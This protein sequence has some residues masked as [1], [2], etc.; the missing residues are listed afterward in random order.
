MLYR[1][2]AVHGGAKAT[3]HVLV[4][5]DGVKQTTLG[6]FGTREEAMQK[7]EGSATMAKS[8]R[9]N[10]EGQQLGLTGSNVAAGEALGSSYKKNDNSGLAA[11]RAAETKGGKEAS[12]GMGATTTDKGSK[13]WEGSSSSASGSSSSTSTA[14]SASGFDKGSVSASASGGGENG[15]LNRI[16][17]AM[18]RAEG[19]TSGEMPNFSMAEKCPKCGQGDCKCGNMG[20]SELCKRCSKAENMC[21]CTGM[22]K[23]RGPG[24]ARRR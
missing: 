14:T 17:A 2:W 19:Q 5:H 16:K 9:L 22:T 7:A 21:K 4:K 1:T 10:K 13:P 8:E 11:I 18:R 20:K 12:P 23:E 15:G 6:Y 24:Q 3:K